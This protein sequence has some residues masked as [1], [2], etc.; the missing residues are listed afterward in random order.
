MTKN[1]ALRYLQQ[2]PKDVSKGNTGDKVTGILTIRASS[3][4][5][6]AFSPGVTNF[7]P[8]AGNTLE[9]YVDRNV[10]LCICSAS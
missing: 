9:N 6:A 1:E 3:R 10:H 4:L 2:G 5:S 7:K 8:A